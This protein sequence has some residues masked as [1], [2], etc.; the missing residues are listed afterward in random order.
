MHV[1]PH[2]VTFK[3]FE[4]SPDLKTFSMGLA[5]VSRQSSPSS[6]SEVTLAGREI[7]RSCV[8]VH[9]CP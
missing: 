4:F 7:H 6:R 9:A 1:P 5:E 2:A 8:A 3:P